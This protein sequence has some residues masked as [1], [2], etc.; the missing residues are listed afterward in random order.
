MSDLV[1]Q[2]LA[3]WSG[4]GDFL[5]ADED[6]TG[7]VKLLLYEHYRDI[8]TEYMNGGRLQIHLD[9][10]SF[11]YSP[12]KG[13]ISGLASGVDV[14]VRLY[15]PFDTFDGTAGVQ[16]AAHSLNEDSN[17]SWVENKEAFDLDGSGAAKTDS[18]QGNGHCIATLD[19]GDEDITIA[20]IIRRGTDADNPG[21]VIR[22]V[23]NSNYA[24]VSVGETT[25]PRLHKV[26]AGTDTEVGYFSGNSSILY[27][28]S[29]NTSHF[30]EVRCHGTKIDLFIDGKHYKG[31]VGISPE[32]GAGP[33]WTLDN[34]AINDGTKF[35]LWA[36]D[37]TDAE[38]R[39]FG[40]HRVLFYG[41]IDDIKPRPKSNYCV[42]TAFDEFES[43]K[44]EEVFS[45]T[46][47]GGGANIALGGREALDS[48]DT[49]IGSVLQQIWDASIS[50]RSTDNAALKAV[51]GSAL[52]GIL[53]QLQ[54]EE[55]G[56]QYM[57]GR[58]SVFENRDH[59][60]ADSHA[61]SIG[62]YKDAY[63]GTNPAFTDMEFGE[64]KEGVENRIVV[65]ARRATE[66]AA[67]GVWQ[68]QEVADNA[69]SFNA[70][71]PKLFLAEVT[72]FDVAD[73]WVTPVD[74]T[75][76][77]ANTQADGGGTDISSELTVTL[78]ET[79]RYDG[80][81]RMIS[82]TFGATAGFL[83][84]LELRADGWTYQDKHS[85]VEA[86]STSK[87][88]Y[89]ER[90]K[91]ID[92]IFL[93]DDAEARAL[94]VSR[95][96]RRDDPKR[97]HFITT[98]ASDKPTLHAMMQHRI[99]DRITLNYSDHGINEDYYIEGESWEI[100]PGGKDVKRVL[101]LRQV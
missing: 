30:M 64:G 10:T 17:Y 27:T 3:D 69:I 6:I 23:D 96:A 89:G 75:D 81:R 18:T 24:Y 82:V 14:V 1:L 8:E 72:G 59:R 29:D 46:N 58:V 22:Y 87:D 61:A 76:Y 57:M 26:I 45:A 2:V 92:C 49:D 4:D 97:V 91:V 13:T 95:E 53:F 88:N 84:K 73:N 93:S 52:E 99:S 56:F 101:Q 28:W 37:E 20:G 42:I 12:T 80:I 34:A 7:D 78:V 65:N 77:E 44:K 71:E 63:D 90:R 47:L 43:L 74:N 55:D 79:A 5:D 68:S 36:K 9:N 60:T 16:L 100:G 66:T 98:M 21:F 39:E 62:T 33:T 54:D 67:T 32:T 19:F 40:G 51:T 35:G 86:D 83:T 31:D 41:K 15:Y 25:G 85:I 70:S 38:W 11:K 48:V 50:L 94:A